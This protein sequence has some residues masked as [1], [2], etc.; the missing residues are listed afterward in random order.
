[1]NRQEDILIEKYGRKGGWTVPEGYFESVYK[2]IDAKLPSFPEAPRH[3]EMTAWQRMKP[4]VYLAAMFAGIW[5]MIHLHLFR[6][7]RNE[8]GRPSQWCQTRIRCSKRDVI[9]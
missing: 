2:E 9:R 5:L 3:V 7:P 1:M 8:S 6:L 4:Y